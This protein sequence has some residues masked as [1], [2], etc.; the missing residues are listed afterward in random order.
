MMFIDA[1]AHLSDEEYA[2]DIDEVI[3]E[4]KNANVVALVKSTPYAK[5]NV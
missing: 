5:K 1:H 3:A 2:E 4:A